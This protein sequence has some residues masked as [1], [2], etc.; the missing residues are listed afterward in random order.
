MS[1]A[2]AMIVKDEIEDLKRCLDSCWYIFDEICI[3]DTSPEEFIKKEFDEDHYDGIGIKIE[4]YRWCDDFAAARNRAFSMCES[5]WVMWLD[6]DDIIKNSE[7]IRHCWMDNKDKYDVIAFPY[8]YTHDNKGDVVLKL[9]RERIIRRNKAQWLYP[10]HECLKLEGLMTNFIY[11]DRLAVS[12]FRNHENRVTDRNIKIFEKAFK[13]NP[14]YIKDQR[15]V[16]YY[17]NELRDNSKFEEAIAMYKKI[18]DLFGFTDEKYLAKIS[19]GVCYSMISKPGEAIFA[20]KEALAMYPEYIDAY[21][22][23]GVLEFDSQNYRRA[24]VLFQSC[25]NNGFAERMLSNRN[26]FSGY[27]A[28][29]YLEKIYDKLGEHEKSLEMAEKLLEYFPNL[30]S[31]RNDVRWCKDRMIDKYSKLMPADGCIRLNLGSGGQKKDGFY[32][33]DKYD[34][35]AD[36]HF[37]M[38][39]IPLRD[40]TVSM[41]RSEHSLEHL[42]YRKALE[43]IRECSR[44]LVKGGILDLEIPDFEE[45]ATEMFRSQRSGDFR[46]ADWYQ[47]TIWGR[48]YT[49]NNID[50]GQFHNCGFTKESII[51]ILES[52]GFYIQNIDSSNKYGTP[53][54][55]IIAVKKAMVYYLDSGDIKSAT[56]RLRRYPIHE[57]KFDG[58]PVEIIR[59]KDLNGIGA[60]ADAVIF[61][62]FSAEALELAKSLKIQGV[63]R[64]YDHNEAILEFGGVAEMLAEMDIVF[65]CGEKL[66]EL[67][68]LKTGVK[69]CVV[70]EDTYEF[71][72]TM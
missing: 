19:L 10:I 17:A 3:L 14:E 39:F 50:K 46:K 41:I 25:V 45:C 60:D 2:L 55:E 4:T 13:D 40:K 7:G 8:H 34:K 63:R 24:L 56:S 42:T 65:C 26:D 51:N 23:L 69:N 22:Y 33:I 16:Y 67:T 1:L 47:M 62:S 64:Y 30:E 27:K 12:H 20:L 29:E 57:K 31:L 71:A 44:V 18:D 68:E 28:Y 53:S 36:F 15:M 52:V 35:R 58:A 70:L 48:Q 32:S 49:D 43:C 61:T 11:D 21:W 37:D 5:E 59:I 66:K 54:L 72:R 6:V 38:S 9:I